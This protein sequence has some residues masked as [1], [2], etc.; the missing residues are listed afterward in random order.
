L[1]SNSQKIKL[2]SFILKT[3][4]KVNAYILKSQAGDCSIVVQ[5][6]EQYYV[7]VQLLVKGLWKEKK[8]RLLQRSARS[9]KLAWAS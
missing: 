3:K 1:F 8:P 9:L 7:F 6:F 2:Q 5:I 4:A